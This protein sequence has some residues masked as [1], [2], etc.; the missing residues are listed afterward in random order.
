MKQHIPRRSKFYSGYHVLCHT[1]SRNPAGWLVCNYAL[2]GHCP[3]KSALKKYDTVLGTSTLRNHTRT[4]E[5]QNRKTTDMG[6]AKVGSVMKGEVIDAA[7]YAVVEGLLPL[8]FAYN[9]HGLLVFATSLVEA[10]RSV[11]M[12][13]EVDVRDLLPSNN[14]VRD[15]VSR[16]ARKQQE[17]FRNNE[18]QAILD[19]GGGVTSDGLK[20]DTTGTKYYDFVI[21]YF[22][23]G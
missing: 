21:H 11:P 14:A 15:G 13:T 18:L 16:L 17:L 22:R 3:F 2:S 7:V 4:H 6:V 20:Q 19:C 5:G 1:N 12:A 9:K 8:S 23:L 10:G